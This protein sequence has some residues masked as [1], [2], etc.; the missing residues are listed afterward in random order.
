LP[1][2]G[3]VVGS[4]VFIKVPD[5]N[6]KSTEKFTLISMLQSL[7]IIGFLLFAPT[8]IMFLL[9]LEW[10]G[11]TYA[12]GSATIIGLFCGTAGMVPVFL[13]WEY[14]AGDA[15][16]IPLSMIRQRIVWSSCLTMVFFSAN[17]MCQSYYMAIYFQ[18][19]R[20]K[21]PTLSGVF[22][23]PGILSQMVMA[24]TSGVL[25]QYLEFLHHHL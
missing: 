19:I 23:L 21:S 14:K 1:I 24:V 20:G 15:A 17:M 8:A 3:I 9:A 13:G 4:L 22:V 2:G 5:R 10:G 7:D 25:G 6:A 12:W 18:S 16:M 11:T